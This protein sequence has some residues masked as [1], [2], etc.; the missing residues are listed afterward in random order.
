MRT[1]FVLSEPFRIWSPAKGL[2]KVNVLRDALNRIIHATEFKVGFDRLPDDASRIRDGA[3]GVIY[4]STQTDQRDEALIDV[5]ALASCFF[6]QG[7]PAL[8]PPDRP[9][10]LEAVH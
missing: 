10:T 1:K 9:S 2:T 7:L 3:I 5:F 4:L 6:H 8:Q